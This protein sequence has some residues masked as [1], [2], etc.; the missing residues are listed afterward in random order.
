[1]K[2][3]TR[4]KSYYVF[5][6]LPWQI[7]SAHILS[8]LGMALAIRA[9][10]GLNASYAKAVCTISHTPDFAPSDDRVVE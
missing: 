7:E 6:F 10:E 8:F 2:S 3:A 5:F 9:T 1:M 4:S